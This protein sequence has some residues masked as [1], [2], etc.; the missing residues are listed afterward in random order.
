MAE[1]CLTRRMM[2]V[3]SFQTRLAIGQIERAVAEV[4]QDATRGQF[5]WN[6][7]GDIANIA[8]LL[9]AEDLEARALQVL[10]QA[11]PP[12]FYLERAAHTVEQLE[13]EYPRYEESAILDGIRNIGREEAHVRLALARC[14]DEAFSIAASATEIEEIA[15][16]QAVVGD[17]E[18]ALNSVHRLVG[19]AQV[20]QRLVLVVIALELVRR[21]RVEEAR[22]VLS[23]LEA[24]IAPTSASD[25]WHRVVLAAGLVGRR[26]WDGYPYPDY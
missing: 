25:T 16:T 2:T 4:E 3:D 21:R 26:P 20:R 13:R 15:E 18:A 1:T 10:R 11:S 17:L 22:V 7:I 24:Q 6:L 9:G 12:Q 5:V 19:P 23:H 14:Y 8:R